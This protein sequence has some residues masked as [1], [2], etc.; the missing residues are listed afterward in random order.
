MEDFKTYSP[1]G[2]QTSFLTKVF[3]WLFIALAISAVSAIG[4]FWVLSWL[5]LGIDAYF[6]VL[7]FSTIAYFALMIFIQVRVF[8]NRV[9][10]AA[11]SI[12]VPFIL[13]AI[14]MGLEL[15]VLMLVYTGTSLAL[16][17]GVCALV[18][19]V[20]AA[21][22]YFTKRNLNVMGAIATSVIIGSMVLALVNWFMKSESIYW[23][24]SFA[25]FGAVMLITSVD[26]WRMKNDM[27][28][29]NTGNENAMFWAFHLYVDFVYM[30]VRIVSFL[31]VARRN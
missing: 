23:I 5:N 3:G 8:K 7:V 1:A 9:G 20:M 22:G 27:L 19:G 11:K 6:N 28:M 25:T 13:Y 21:Y 14:V 15:S 16:S 24:I 31:G 26:V 4:I 17:F 10:R 30:F 18:F 12:T 29:G 2:T